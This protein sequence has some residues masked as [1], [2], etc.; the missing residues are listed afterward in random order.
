MPGRHHG[1][2]V[3]P[4]H[5]APRSVK[6]TLGRFVGDLAGTLP[7]SGVTRTVAFVGAAGVAFGLGVFTVDAE[8]NPDDTTA[9]VADSF[10]ATTSLSDDAIKA[11]HR[12]SADEVSRSA[13]RSTSALVQRET[14]ARHLAAAKQDMAGSISKTVAATDPRDIAKSMLDDHGWSSDQFSCLDSLWV[15]ESN[16]NV[17]ATNSYSGAYGIPQALPAEKMASAGPNW[18]TDPAT[19]IEWGLD[20]IRSSYGSPCSAWYFKESNNWY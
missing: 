11:R 18:R 2:H 16:W 17:Y 6:Q 15:S 4:R 12:H 19:Q 9:A 1:R 5:R 10:D 8:A 20:Y 14:K 7:A 13:D 3:A